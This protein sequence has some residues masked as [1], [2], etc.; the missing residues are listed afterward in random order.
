MQPVI[1]INSKGHASE[2]DQDYLQDQNN[3]NY[4]YK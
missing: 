3:E 2:G 1:G 4:N